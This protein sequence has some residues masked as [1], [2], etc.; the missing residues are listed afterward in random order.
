MRIYV[1]V[2]K[3]LHVFPGLNTRIIVCDTNDINI[4]ILIIV[5][6]HIINGIYIL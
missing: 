1:Q 6:I 3:F 4:I 2:L 5:Q